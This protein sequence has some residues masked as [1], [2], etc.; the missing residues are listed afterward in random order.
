MGTDEVHFG[1]IIPTFLKYNEV[2]TIN[3]SDFDLKEDLMKEIENYI[4]QYK[5]DKDVFWDKTI[6]IRLTHSL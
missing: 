1:E 6:I 4:L 5:D 2:K 3:F